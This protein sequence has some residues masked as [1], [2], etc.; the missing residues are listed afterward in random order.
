MHISEFRKISKFVD[1]L[2]KNGYDLTTEFCDLLLDLGFSCSKNDIK[3][4]FR[5]LF[6]IHYINASENINMINTINNTNAENILCMCDELCI[7]DYIIYIFRKKIRLDRMM[8]SYIINYNEKNYDPIVDLYLNGYRVICAFDDSSIADLRIFTNDSMQI[9]RTI[10][11]IKNGV[12]VK[13]LNM[14]YATIQNYNTLAVTNRINKVNFPDIET[15]SFNDI[16]TFDDIHIFCSKIDTLNNVTDIRINTSY[17]MGSKNIRNIISANA[18]LKKLS[19]ICGDF[20]C[21]MDFLFYSCN[22]YHSLIS[23]SVINCNIDHTVFDTCKK[24]KTLYIKNMASRQ[25]NVIH[26]PDTITYLNVDKADISNNMLVRCKRL[27]KLNINENYTISTFKPFEKSLRSVTLSKNT[28]IHDDDIALCTNIKILRVSH[29]YRIT[30]CEP[31]AKSLRVLYADNPNCVVY[32]CGI[33][34]YGIKMCVNLRKLNADGNPHIT[35]C[36]PFAESL[37]ILSACGKCGINDIGLQPCTN[38]KQLCTTGNYNITSASYTK[39]AKCYEPR[40]ISHLIF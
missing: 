29:N 1:R 3:N 38:L 12:Y 15:L 11:G 16:R 26:L 40:S 21:G 18:Q 25:I 33:R 4:P 7:N 22:T 17:D 20:K 30:T 34:D 32:K 5:Y 39:F 13:S 35:T 14:C 27:R 6:N 23:L 10:D 31:F 24:I 19:I 8:D 37:K 28:N 2:I 36:K 9:Y